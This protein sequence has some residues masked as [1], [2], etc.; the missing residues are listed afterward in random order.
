MEIINSDS[1]RGFGKSATSLKVY[2]WMKSLKESNNKIKQLKGGLNQMNTKS[3]YEVISDLEE[4]KRDLI[5]QRDS[6]D[7][8]LRTQAK[9]LR[10][11]KREVEDKEEDIKEFKES[12]KE[13]KETIKELIRSVDQSLERFS[14]L[15][16][17]K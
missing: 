17:K 1:D 5:K 4:K 6:F 14:K 7:D 12:L 13:K 16:S 8:V 11:M 10:E 9:E 15:E 3:R 2:N